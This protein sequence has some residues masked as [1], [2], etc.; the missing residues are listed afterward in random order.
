MLV[1]GMVVLFWEARRFVDFSPWRL[2]AAPTLALVVGMVGAQAAIL[3][4]GVL[5]SPWRTGIVKVSVFLPLFGSL[6]FVAERE[7]VLMTVK[8]LRG[9]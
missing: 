8:I 1:V 4:P 7:Q 3:I 9:I 6:L 2:F 5:G